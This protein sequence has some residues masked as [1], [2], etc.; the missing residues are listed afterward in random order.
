MLLTFYQK[1]SSTV[2]PRK[3]ACGV[4]EDYD[5]EINFI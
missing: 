1:D 4:Q 5:K 2:T 3:E